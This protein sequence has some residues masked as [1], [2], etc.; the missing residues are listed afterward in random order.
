MCVP[1]S[2]GTYAMT[3][4]KSET[5]TERKGE[6]KA[7]RAGLTDTE[8]LVRLRLDY[9]S[10]DLGPLEDGTAEVIRRDLPDYFRR[11][12]NR[13]LFVYVI[14]EGSDIVSCAFLLVMEKPMSP[15]FPNGRTGTVLNVYTRPASRRKGYARRVM[16]ALIAGAEQMSLSVLELKAT[17]DGYDLYRSVGFADDASGYRL[18]KLRYP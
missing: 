1:R 3:D 12:L 11:K 4:P 6:E 15:A 10:E 2:G 13:D 17:E 16:E 5:A 7:G 18:M 9:L 14:R 8:A